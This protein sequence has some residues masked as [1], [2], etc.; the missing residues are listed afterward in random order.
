[1][2]NKKKEVGFVIDSNGEKLNI[3]GLF[4]E[5]Y[6][7]YRYYAEINGIPF[8]SNNSEENDYVLEKSLGY[9]SFPA[10]K[11][12]DRYKVVWFSYIDYPYF[13]CI[14]IPEDLSTI[15]D[16]QKEK[17]KECYNLINNFRYHELM[18]V[19]KLSTYEPFEEIII[20][21][22]NAIFDIVE[23][24]LENVQPFGNRKKMAKVLGKK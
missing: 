12:V 19:P 2:E 20:Q 10:C 13:L 17:I 15:T 7:N 18:L 6:K 23:G 11:M 9:N 14:Y 24:G 21:Q 22:H 16:L 8:Y 4:D 1:M 5:H 3:Y